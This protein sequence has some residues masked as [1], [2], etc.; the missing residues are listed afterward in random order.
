MTDNSD[1]VGVVE[2]TGSNGRL[3]GEEL[4]E[5][6]G[7]YTFHLWSEIGLE[8]A[9]QNEQFR[10][11]GDSIAALRIAEIGEVDSA[12]VIGAGPSI[13]A[14]RT[15]QAI[16]E[17]GYRGAVIATESGLSH[18]LPYGL[19]PDL[20]VTVDPR[21]RIARWFG[22]PEMTE[23]ELIASDYYRVS[24][25]DPFYKVQARPD[26]PMRSLVEKYGAKMKI[27]L[28]TS[29]YRTVVDRVL[30]VG[31]EIY[32]W[33][34]MFDDPDQPDSVTRA[35]QKKNG[36]P[37]INAGG[38]VGS[39]AW[40]IAY[41]VLGKAH[42]AVTGMDY[43]V[44]EGT[45]YEQLPHYKTCANLMGPEKI[46]QAVVKIRNPYNNRWYMTDPTYLWY[47]NSF[48]EMVEDAHPECQTY[49]C[50]QG[51]VLFGNSMHYDTLSDFIALHG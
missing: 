34:P 6:I 18:C 45:P 16:L 5:K 43:S 12:I 46:D 47:R 36:L 23:D 21:P 10:D 8:N 15:A 30:D 3:L 42:V 48:L 1:F 17:S 14:Q 22:Y 27:A 39:A 26:D 13:V 51:G 37:S 19:V 41:A 29:A 32:W 2:P 28:P 31:M 33:N 7:E 9:R 50:T 38:N 35:L 20:V 49:N 11:Q 25:F 24:D 44:P 40:M 4:A